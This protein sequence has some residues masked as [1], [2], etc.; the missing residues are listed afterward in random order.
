MK[1]VMVITLYSYSPDI[2]LERLAKTTHYSCYPD[3]VEIQDSDATT[4]LFC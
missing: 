4:C 2:K 3:Q 1:A